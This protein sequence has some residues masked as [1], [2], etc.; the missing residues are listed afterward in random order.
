MCCGKK[1]SQEKSRLFDSNSEIS[2]S[3][4]TDKGTPLSQGIAV[5]TQPNFLI[6]L[7]TPRTSPGVL[8][9][10]ALGLFQHWGFKHMVCPY[11]VLMFLAVNAALRF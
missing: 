4:W 6:L 8:V 7:G 9:A 2:S 3:T 5:C 10:P 1:K 11:N